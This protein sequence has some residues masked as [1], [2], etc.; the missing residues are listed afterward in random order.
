MRAYYA[1]DMDGH[2]AAMTGM[3]CAKA[4]SINALG[5]LQRNLVGTTALR[6]SAVYFS[7]LILLKRLLYQ[8]FVD[9]ISLQEF[10]LPKY[11]HILSVVFHHLK[12]GTFERLDN[13]MVRIEEGKRTILVSLSQD[14]QPK[15]LID[16]YAGAILLKRHWYQ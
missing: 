2:F 8:H 12:N 13:R 3:A 4:D 10:Q 7:T 16:E 5:S 14:P 6:S 9:G 1:K 15:L 11:D